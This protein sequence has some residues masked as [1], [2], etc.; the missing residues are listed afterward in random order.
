MST[1]NNIIIGNYYSQ[2]YVVHV[3]TSREELPYG[4]GLPN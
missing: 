1:T 4:N 2:Q 3:A